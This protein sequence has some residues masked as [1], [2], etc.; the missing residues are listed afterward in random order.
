[1]AIWSAEIKELER[2][3]ES[4]KGQLP[5]LEKELERL[6]KTDDENIIL[7]YAR[8][9]LEVIITDL[10][11]C[12]LKRPRKTE[13]LKGIIDKLNKEEKVPSNIITSMDH[14]NSLSA[15]GA[16]PKDFDP[17]Q[18]KP[19]LVNLDIIIKWYLKYKDTKT[20]QKKDTEEIK[21]GSKILG[22][23]TGQIQKQKKRMILLFSGLT[24]IFAAVVVALFVF[25]IIGGGNQN[26]ELEKSIAVLPFRNDSPEDSTQYF[27]DGVMEELLNKLQLIGSLRVIGRTSV[28][29]F[30][31]QN[32]S[33]L[34]IAKELDVNYIVEGSGQKSGKSL[35]MRVQLLTAKNERHLWGDSFEQANLEISDYFKAQ[36]G[37]A[38]AI[39]NKLNAALSAQEEKRIKKVPSVNLEAYEDYLKS[40]WVGDLSP[41]ALLKAKDYLEDAIKK[42]PD[43]APLYS[44][45]AITWLSMSATGAESPDIAN[46][47]VYENLNKALEL[48]PEVE[49]AHY[50]SAFMAW[51]FEWDWEKAETEFLNTIAINPNNGVARL[52]YSLML[53]NLQR[54][55][56]ARTQAELGYKLD[57][58]NPDI[59]ALYTPAL[60]MGGDC[61]SAISMLRPLL[62][63]EPDNAFYNAQMAA[64]A[65][66]CGD[67]DLMFR[68]DI[69]T[70]PL[71]QAEVSEIQKIYD[72]KGFVA[73]YSEI[74]RKLEILAEKEYISNNVFAIMYYFI[75][76]DEKA[77]DYLEEAFEKHENIITNINTK[78]WGLPRLYNNPRF[79]AILNKM[80]L[81]L[82]TTD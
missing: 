38:E 49:G 12:E 45:M 33:V 27:M 41:E 10:C 61:K 25:N 24:L 78:Y 9:C 31:G 82:P 77:L 53:Y 62:E 81:P 29:Q 43:W 65:W 80:N 34:E 58:L 30:R 23:T 69:T 2:L 64:A 42:A 22:N 14:L 18:V 68:V 73:A 72:E 37:F 36:S 54:P 1:M 75:E 15:Y 63:K 47:L 44:A 39:A 59:K 32:K 16:H 7:V 70:Y 71:T 35:R 55:E 4:F 51:T 11:E 6:L 40:N 76:N 66:Q 5:D 46:P 48:D 79:I 60:I 57:P 52:H 74:I 13:P 3:Y 50:I 67:L 28:E 20:N 17:E 21:N 19:V 56:E 8:R 26:K